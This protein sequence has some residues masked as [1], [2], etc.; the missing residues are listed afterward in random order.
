LAHGKWEGPFGI[1]AEI[2]S[3][4]IDHP[5]PAVGDVGAS[6]ASAKDDSRA[7][8]AAAKSISEEDMTLAKGVLDDLQQPAMDPTESPVVTAL[9][10]TDGV[11]DRVW[12]VQGVNARAA[13][14]EASIR[15]EDISRSVTGILVGRSNRADF[16]IDDES[17]SRNHARFVYLDGALHVEDLDSMNGTWVDGEKLAANDQQP[18][19]RASDV[20]FGKI[21]LEVKEVDPT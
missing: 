3:A 6:D 11:Q 4:A 5:A 7:A 21:R 2:R 16:I 1:F 13:N 20:E 8:P 14:I 12:L 10:L 15:E 19:R 18:L 17:V 9:P